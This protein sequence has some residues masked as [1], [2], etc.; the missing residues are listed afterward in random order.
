M[1]QSRHSVRINGFD[2]SDDE[3]ATIAVILSA[4]QSDKNPTF[5]RCF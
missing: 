2:I 1:I 5:N 3:Q 4:A